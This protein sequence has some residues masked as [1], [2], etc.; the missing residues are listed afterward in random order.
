MR[1]NQRPHRAVGKLGTALVATATAATSV[2]GI[3]SAAAVAD[4]ETVLSSDFEGDSPAPWSG[5]G[6]TVSLDADA[7]SGAQA[8]KVTGRTA[9]WNGAQVDVS[10]LFTAGE[11]HV[12]GWVKLVAGQAPT[13]LNFGVSQPGAANEYPWVGSR[14][15]V[16]DGAWVQLDG[17]YTVHPETP[18]TILYVE[19]AS[20]TAEFL[21]DDVVVTGPPPATTV[22]S[23]LDFEGGSTWAPWTQSG[24]DATTLGVVPDPDD[25]ANSVLQVANRSADYVGIESP[26]LFHEGTEYTFSAR[27]RL[28]PDAPADTAE[29]RFVV[30]AGYHWV[31]NATITK[32]GWTT[33]TGTRIAD[34]DDAT[35]YV[36]TSD[37]AVGG[38]P[39]PYT[40][41]VDDVL[42]TAPGEGCPGLPPDFVPGGAIDPT[43][44]PVA[45][46]QGFGNV[47][48]LTF[49]DGP[50]PGTTPTLL[51]FLAA[52]G[53]KAT[54]CVIGQNI[55]APGGAEIL[56]RIVAEG[57]VLCNH[58]TSYADMGSW[59]PEQIQQ[60]LRTS[61]SSAPRCPTPTRRCRSS[62]RPTAAGA[63]RHRWRWTSGCSRSR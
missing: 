39:V 4:P 3:T 38:S 37:I 15:P 1:R 63:P 26:A 56:R 8:L 9:G 62:A 12:T 16:T 29:A 27:V 13:E 24:G 30:K 34:A 21:L 14:L 5:R 17:Y 55:E 10:T 19:S 59:T 20:A 50:N 44:T 11:Y 52:N 57:H 36:G 61:R 32:A 40:Y 58:T 42:I 48:A 2:V 7:H 47:A 18:P 22:V 35:V 6:A 45:T 60:D 51:D 46:A 53:I 23:S 31:G 43:T 49:D 28:A 33:L 54:F 41:L 25:P